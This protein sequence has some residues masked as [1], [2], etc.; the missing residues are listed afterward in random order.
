MSGFVDSMGVCIFH[1]YVCSFYERVCRFYEGV[2]RLYGGFLDSVRG[3][4][5]QAHSL[6]FHIYTAT[7]KNM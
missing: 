4:H 2:C 6:C 5:A 1:E 7:S 3:F